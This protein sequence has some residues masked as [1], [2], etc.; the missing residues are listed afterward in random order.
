MT[1]NQILNTIRN[2]VYETSPTFWTDGE[3]FAYMW[4]AECE[5][6]ALIGCTQS[7]DTSITTVAGTQEYTRPSDA[8][9]ISRVTWNYV[10]LKK[11]D[12]RDKDSLEFPSYGDSTNRTGN[13]THF[14][15]YGDLIGFWPVPPSA[16]PVKIYYVK[17]PDE[18]TASSS[19]FTVPQL[20]HHYI[21]D[22]VLYRMYAKDQDETRAQLHKQAWGE[23]IIA[24]RQKWQS[25]TGKGRF[26]VVRDESQ[27]QT[28]ELGIV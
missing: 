13:C 14:Y 24:A 19:T 16:S 15:E 23:H 17:Q 1:P 20:F 18:I 22:Y 12:L 5:L 7:T 21:P 9:E 10:P 3:V 6:A 8:L 11:I 26:S 25:R 27:S 4:Q 2:Q 28:T